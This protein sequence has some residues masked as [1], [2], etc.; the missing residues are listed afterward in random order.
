MYVSHGAFDTYCFDVQQTTKTKKTP[1]KSHIRLPFYV[2]RNLLAVS[3]TVYKRAHLRPQSPISSLHHQPHQPQ[4][5]EARRK[6]P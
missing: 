6:L 5:D 1:C 2:V 4:K 3:S